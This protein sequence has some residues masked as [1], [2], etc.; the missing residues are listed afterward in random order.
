MAK[1]D[2][3]MLIGSGNVDAFT[4][5]TV[6]EYQVALCWISR[7]YLAVIGPGT[8][9]ETYNVHLSSVLIGIKN[10]FS[11]ELIITSGEIF[12][13]AVFIGAGNQSNV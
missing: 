12:V 5:R 8:G 7:G 10:P 1:F 2:N 9:D 13:N 3:F 11:H 4:A 6:S